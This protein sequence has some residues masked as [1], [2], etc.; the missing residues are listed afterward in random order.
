LRRRRRRRRKRRRRRSRR[1]SRRAWTMTTTRTTTK[2][3][4]QGPHLGRVQ[5]P[6]PAAVEAIPQA[7]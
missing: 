3:A 2:E 7:T 5:V 6:D 1:R 4:G